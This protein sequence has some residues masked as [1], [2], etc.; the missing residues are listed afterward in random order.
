MLDSHTQEGFDPVIKGE[1][2]LHVNNGGISFGVVDEGFGPTI[3]VNQ[4]HFGAIDTEQRVHTTK[5]MLR[6]VGEMFIKASKEE[7]SEN[8]CFPAEVYSAKK[9]KTSNGSPG[10]ETMES[11]HIKS[12]VPIN[13]DDYELTWTVSEYVGHEVIRKSDY[14]KFVLA[15][16]K[17]EDLEQFYLKNVDDIQVGD[18][19]VLW[20]SIPATVIEGSNGDLWAECSEDIIHTLEFAI[21]GRECW[22]STC[23]CNLNGIEKLEI[24]DK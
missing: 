7:Y 8:Y 22:V 14:E 11:E 10:G 15:R 3:L 23:S 16:R 20:A 12:N 24:G 4:N 5:D 19:L 21:D 6:Q 18:E 17:D 13:E 9:G 2:H 1:V